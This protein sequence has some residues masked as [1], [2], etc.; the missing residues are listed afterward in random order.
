MVTAKFDMTPLFTSLVRSESM[1]SVI[2]NTQ[3]QIISDL[4]K[5]PFEEVLKNLENARQESAKALL[6]EY[7]EHFPQAFGDESQ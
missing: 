7:K 6:K 2:L 1:L 3:A 4:E 5:K